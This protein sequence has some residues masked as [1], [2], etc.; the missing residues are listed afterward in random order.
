VFYTLEKYEEAIKDCE[1][2][3]EIDPNFTKVSLLLFSFLYQTNYN[4]DYLARRLTSDKDLPFTS[5]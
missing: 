3:I 2:A 5:K 4:T 1:R